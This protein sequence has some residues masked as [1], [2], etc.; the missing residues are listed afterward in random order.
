MEP[1]VRCMF[2]AV[3][4]LQRLLSIS[5]ASSCEAERSFSALRRL[6]TRLRSTISQV[7][8]NHDVICHIHRNILSELSCQD[9]TKEF[10][11]SSDARC[12]C[13]AKYKYYCSGHTSTTTWNSAKS[14]G[15]ASD[16]CA[17]CESRKS[18]C[19]DQNWRAKRIFGQIG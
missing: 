16:E 7:R 17:W 18:K 12:V 15:T 13:L 14:E 10:V 1:N 9:I 6:K 2:P 5:P 11:R 4:K 3:E 19:L 8:L